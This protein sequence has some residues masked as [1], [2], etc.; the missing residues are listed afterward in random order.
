MAKQQSTDMMNLAQEMM[1]IQ[2]DYMLSTLQAM[3]PG[4]SDSAGLNG[5]LEQEIETTRDAV[6]KT[7]SL[8]EKAIDELRKGTREI[9]GVNGVV[10]MMSEVSRGALQMR[11]QLWRTWFDQMRSAQQTTPTSASKS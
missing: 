8:E 6:E 2:R 1:T 3:S 10:D 4:K 11:G 5:M 9:P 7:L